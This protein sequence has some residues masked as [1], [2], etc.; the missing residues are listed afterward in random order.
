MDWL[1]EVHYRFRL[2]SETLYQTVW[3]I[4]AYLSLYPIIRARLQLL[5]IAALLISCKVQE[6][7]YPQLN[8]LIDITDGAYIKEELTQMEAHILKVLNFNI[9]APNAN[10]FYRL[11]W[12]ARNNKNLQWIFVSDNGDEINI[13][14]VAR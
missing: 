12:E 10:E 8:E 6:I 3:I 14:E 9:M 1:V 5:G 11:D 13:D 7:Y 4:D 2:K